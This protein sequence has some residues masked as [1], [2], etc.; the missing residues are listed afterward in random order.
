VFEGGIE[1]VP[2]RIA[3][4]ATTSASGVAALSHEIRDHPV[5]NGVVVIAFTGKE[6]KIVNRVGNLAGE[7]RYLDVTF[8]GFEHGG[9][10]FCQVQFEIRGFCP[11]FLCHDSLLEVNFIRG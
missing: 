8:V 10:F 7:K 4:T 2:E 9:I 1:L 3:R 6:N 5:K 11:L